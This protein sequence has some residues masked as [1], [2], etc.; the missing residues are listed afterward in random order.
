MGAGMS[1]LAAW[2][3]DVLVGPICPYG[4]GYRARGH[5]TLAAHGRLEHAGDS[6]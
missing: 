3:L 1:N 4:C 2:L 6:L 5:R